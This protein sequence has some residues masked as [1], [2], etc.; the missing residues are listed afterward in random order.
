MKNK[1]MLLIGIVGFIMIG[2]GIIIGLSFSFATPLENDVKLEEN[3][4]LI[5]YIEVNYD[6]K[7]G[8]AVSSSDSA[9]AQVYSDYIYVEDKI[10]EGLTFKGFVET[11]DGTI[12]AVKR[13]DNS[14][15]A[16]YVDG[17][18]SGLKYDSD[19]RTV[20]FKVNYL[21]AGCKIT[22]GI[23]TQ[24]PT[25]SNGIYRM[26]FYNTAYGREGSRSTKSNTVHAFVG[27][28]NISPFNVIYQYTGDVPDG[29]PEVPAV[30]SYIAGSTVSVNQDI[31]IEGYEFSGW[32]TDDVSVSDGVFIMPSSHVTFQGS[33]TKKVEKKQDVTYTITGEIPDG[34]LPPLDKSYVVGS[35]VKLDSL[36]AGDIINGYRFLGWTSSDVELPSTNIDDSIIF[37]MPDHSVTLV[38]MFARIS[39]K[40]TYQFQGSVIPPNADSLLP[41]EKNYYPGDT[42]TIASYP[43]ATGYKF[44]GWYSSEQFT[45]P[46]EDVIIYGEWMVEEGV[47]SPTITVNIINKQESY[48]NSDVV[49]FSI[50]VENTADYPILDVML[51]EKT[52]DCIF[53]DGEGYTVRSNT[54]VL[55]PT[56][57]A[58]SSVTVYASYNVG[59]DVVKNVTNVVQLTGALASNSNYHLDISKEYK[60]AVDFVISNIALQIT[61]VNEDGENISGAEFT[62]YRDSNLSNVVSTGFEFTGLSPNKTYYLKQTR[63]STGY[64][65]LGKALEIKVANDGNIIIPDYDVSNDNGVNKVSIVNK[66]I[67]ILPNTGGVGIIPYIVVGLILIIGGTVCLVLLF[68]KRGE[69]DEKNH[70]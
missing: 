32:T 42:V 67:N 24:T 53:V 15:C 38:G 33:F 5:Y 2:V 60:S 28:E 13:S 34:Y 19:T 3:S 61:L 27:R 16:G 25:L 39:Y 49:R 64:Q 8:S 20:S 11:D 52:L 41:I 63:A 51:E 45:M 18:V 36:K 30:T 29:V 4:E 40:V 26:D 31:N 23:I 48:H 57:D 47:F 17:G 56:I 54:Q 59:T 6:G 43:N 37:T 46:E 58:H 12:G 1:R 7:D 66:K 65:L 9:T 10:P 22:V 68:R 55:I 35:D 44:L 62:L 14:S 70:G 50:V 21:Q 69:K